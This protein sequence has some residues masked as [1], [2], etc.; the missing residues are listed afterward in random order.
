MNHS[1]NKSQ[2][3][4]VCPMPMRAIEDLAVWRGSDFATAT[5]FTHQLTNPETAEIDAALNSFRER[6]LAHSAIDRN[7]FEL[8]QL[9]KL[10]TRISNDVLLQGRG[11]IV[12]RGLPV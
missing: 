7:N 9:G 4:S 11:F 12:I 5:D 1:L 8:P 10:L 3:S 6:G 2:A